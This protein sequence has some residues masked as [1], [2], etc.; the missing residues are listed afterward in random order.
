MAVNHLA[1]LRV[2]ASHQPDSD[3]RAVVEIYRPFFLAGIISVLTAGCTL[4]AI[5]L[6]GIAAQGN[7]V[8]NVWTPYV[9]AHA[10]SQLYGWVGFFIMGFALQ[11][12][13][14]AQSKLKL[15]NQLAYWSM[16]LMA[17]GI[18][19]RFAA[20]PL[21]QA[22]RDT[23]LPVGV[24]S[25]ILQ[26]I[27]VLLFLANTQLTRFKTGQPLTW[28][29]RFVFASLGW[30]FVVA[31]A[32]P[33]V[34]ANAHQA[35]PL[36]SIQFV[37][38]YFPLYRDAQ[39]LGFVTCMIFGV[40]LVKLNSCFGAK[41]A[42]EEV[43]R[44][45]FSLW[46]FGLIVRMI[47]WSHEFRSG[48]EPGSNWLFVSGGVMLAIAAVLLVVATRVFEPLSNRLSA[49]KFV[50]GA[51]A[52]LLISGVLILLEPLHL[53]LTGAPFSHAYTGGIR[54]AL[55]VGFISQMILGVGLHVVGRM[56]DIPD[57][58]Q[59]SLWPVF[60][61]VNLG[62]AGRVGLQIAT[63]YTPSSFHPMGAT[64]FIELVGLLMWAWYVARPMIARR[65]RVVASAI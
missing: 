56:N 23:W 18:G 10:N 62:N 49:H 50:R 64:G 52:W 59:K 45:A 54:H 11:Q 43:G 36:A 19:V 16:G 34:F 39:F 13:A 20:E 33:F 1:P 5:A 53:R 24:G 63:D 15:F 65:R 41:A 4:G 17:V 40:A 9:L 26:F 55:T 58:V 25:A 42:Y 32:E 3:G 31:L 30:M 6:V 14:P 46:N 22:N 21:V 7:Y 60:V 2:V 12:H 38:E 51:M 61:L 44:I 47:G 37:A 27:A 8:A 57:I 35:D 28:Q 48:F 29:T